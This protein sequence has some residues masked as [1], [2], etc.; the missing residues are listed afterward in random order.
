MTYSHQ[1][2]TITGYGIDLTQYHNS[3][4]APVLEYLIT[5]IDDLVAETNN[6]TCQYDYNQSPTHGTYLYVDAHPESLAH[7]NQQLA[8]FIQSLLHQIQYQTDVYY[9][10]HPLSNHDITILT[11]DIH[12]FINQHAHN[13]KQTIMH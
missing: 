10:E 11:H 9:L 8:D 3:T 7:T 13:F 1:V 5:S 4:Y 12:A 6:H 2:Y